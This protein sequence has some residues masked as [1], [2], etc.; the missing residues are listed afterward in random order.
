MD[1]LRLL[2][3]QAGECAYCHH[4]FP[5]GRFETDHVIPVSRGGPHVLSNIVLACLACNRSKGTMT[6]E[7]F[8]AALC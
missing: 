8:L 7:E 6:S 3:Q 4:P 1:I 2:E 5:G